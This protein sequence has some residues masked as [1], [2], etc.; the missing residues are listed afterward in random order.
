M[1]IILIIPHLSF[2]GGA[3]TVLAKLANYYASKKHEIT[4]ITFAGP[5]DL[6]IYDLTADIKLVQLNCLVQST[7][8]YMQILSILKRLILLRKELKF[9]NPDVII[10]F[11][12]TVNI[13]MLIAAFG[14]RKTTIVTERTDPYMHKLPTLY[15]WLRLKLYPLADYIV[16]Q[17]EHYQ[18]YFT[19]ACQRRIKIIPNGVYP[20]S[21]AVKK[22]SKFPKHIV[23][24][25]RLMWYKD[26][27]T[28]IKS[29]TR[30]AQSYPDITLTIYG[31]GPERTKLKKLIASSQLEARVFL[32]GQSNCVAQHL[33]QAD[34][35]VFPSFYEGFSN[36]LCEA[37][38]AG[39]PTIAS[40]C[41]GNISIINDG[42]NGRVFNIGDVGMLSNLIKK[43]LDDEQ[44]RV[45]LSKAAQQIVIDYS[46]EKFF[47]RWDALIQKQ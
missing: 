45:S 9:Q 37:L 6:P 10:S 36:A 47:A 38:A 13:A 26:H 16:L 23:S 17:S 33:A 12:D 43:L 14:L 40:N 30:I 2:I 21:F 7:R 25:G 46:P 44:Q 31:E 20:S 34:L 8:F 29:F 35:F 18:D 4:I 5:S 15:Q 32:P 22:I 19:D 39:I 42:V 28:L 27:Q 3:E 41:R 1:R 11:M 24:V